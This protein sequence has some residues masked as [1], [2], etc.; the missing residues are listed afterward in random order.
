MVRVPSVFSLPEERAVAVLEEAGFAVQV[1][2][3]F[4]SAVLGLVAGQSPTG[5]QPEGT[6]I[7]ITVT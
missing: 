3:T 4:G 1:D 2:Y 6:T 7:R 5:E